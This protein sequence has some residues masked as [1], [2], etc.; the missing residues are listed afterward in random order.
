MLFSQSH[1][2]CH[3]YLRNHHR[4]NNFIIIQITITVEEVYGLHKCVIC[5]Y[6]YNYAMFNTSPYSKS[7]LS[8]RMT[9]S[10]YTGTSTIG[11]HII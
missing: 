2:A 9:T 10:V 4:Y 3:M 1:I 5:K 7:K 11:T 6:N 8:P